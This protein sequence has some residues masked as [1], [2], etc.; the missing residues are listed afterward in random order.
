MRARKVPRTGEAIPVIGLGTWQTFDVGPSPEERAPRLEVLRAF[1]AAGGRVIDS[2][3]MYGRAEEVTGDLL[4]ELRGSKPATSP[5][6][7]PFLA[8]KVWTTGAAA[9]EAQIR[10]SFRKLRAPV[11]DLFQVHN[12]VDWR[13]QLATLRDLQAAGKV[14]Y[15]GITH[16]STSSFAQMERI[17]RTEKVD[18]VQ[19]PYSAATREAEARLLPA[20]AETGTAVLVMRPFEEGEL[21]RAVRGRPLP[22]WAKELGATAWSQILLKFILAQPAVTAALPATANPKH[23]AENVAAGAGPMPDE[24]LRKRMAAE[25]RF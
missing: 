22:P 12:L 6:N 19:L 25:L 1:L 23:L 2:S 17:L 24:A 18:F 9:G 16:Y 7:G 15:V 8:T 13:T 3:P 20:A 5:S 11:V 14:R 4:A 21:L 10:A